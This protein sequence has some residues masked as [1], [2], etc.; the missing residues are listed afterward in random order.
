MET[1]LLKKAIVTDVIL[2][3]NDIDFYVDPYF[4]F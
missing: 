2:N 1:I 4:I 3:Y